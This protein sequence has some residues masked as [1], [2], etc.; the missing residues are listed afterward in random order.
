MTS[1]HTGDMVNGQFGRPARG[2]GFGLGIGLLDPIAAEASA[3][4][5]G[6]ISWPAEAARRA[7]DRAGRGARLVP[8]SRAARGGPAR[9]RF[10]VVPAI[11]ID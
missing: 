7:L 10:D 8:S 4:S 6:A 2:M 9:Q 3:V 1:N 5:K 11:I